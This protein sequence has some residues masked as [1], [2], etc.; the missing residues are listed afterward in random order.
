MEQKENKNEEIIFDK[1]YDKCYDAII[2]EN[3]LIIVSGFNSFGY[4]CQSD[5]NNYKLIQSYKLEIKPENKVLINLIEF[6]DNLLISC[7]K[8][9]QKNDKKDIKDND[10]NKKVDKTN[11]I[12]LGF[13]RMNFIEEEKKLKDENITKTYTDIKLSKIVVNTKIFWQNFL[14]QF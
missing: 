8:Y 6:N 11:E 2:L 4:Y 9:Y 1:F 13:H 7:F 10:N 3:K 14:I 12:Y 5:K